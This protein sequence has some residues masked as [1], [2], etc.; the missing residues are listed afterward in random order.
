M[1]GI[2]KGANIAFKGTTGWNEMADFLGEL[3]IAKFNVIQPLAQRGEN[4]DRKGFTGVTLLGKCGEKSS[5]SHG[6]IN[7]VNN[8]GLRNLG[9]IQVDVGIL[10]NRS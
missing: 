3:A 8:Y 6:S 5:G 7:S 1:V 9:T 2:A 10:V 4:I